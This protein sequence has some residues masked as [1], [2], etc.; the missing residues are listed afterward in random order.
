MNA[1]DISEQIDN[2]ISVIKSIDYGKYIFLIPILISVVI[3]ISIA[4][5]YFKEQKEKKYFTVQSDSNID[6]IMKFF[7]SLGKFPLFRPL[8]EYLAIKFSMFN[9]KNHEDNVQYASTFLFFA[10]IIVSGLFIRLTIVG[11]IW[12]I[13]LMFMFLGI[14]VI[15]TMM[16]LIFNYARYSLINDLPNIFSSFARKIDS[17][18]HVIQ[19][20]DGVRSD[21]KGP[22]K[23]EIIRLTNVFKRNERKEIESQIAVIE[24]NYSNRSISIMMMLLQHL[25]DYGNHDG[26]R[27]RFLELS[28]T[29]KVQAE[30]QKTLASISLYS[31][32]IATVM[33]LIS[34]I[35]V[36]QFLLAFLS[37][38]LDDGSTY[39]SGNS[40]QMFIGVVLLIWITTVVTSFLVERVGE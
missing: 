10:L 26:V 12:Y 27:E 29:L 23:R 19:I 16:G 38:G 22:M 20:L 35:G 4:I 39:L 30:Q 21:L 40:Y 33:M 37:T 1:N 3:I 15:V 11:N 9:S 17:E 28:A 18:S 24:K 31:M 36:R 5:S 8:I 13:S 34:I 32:I 2:F 25:Y 14:L 6:E 7:M